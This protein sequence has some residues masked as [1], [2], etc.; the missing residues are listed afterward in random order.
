MNSSLD[1]FTSNHSPSH[2]LP[3]SHPAKA[4]NVSGMANRGRQWL[5][6]FF[7]PG[8]RETYRKKEGIEKLITSWLQ[9]TGAGNERIQGKLNYNQRKNG[10]RW[11]VIKLCL[12]AEPLSHWEMPGDLPLKLWPA[13]TWE[14]A[15]IQSL[16]P[17]PRLAA[18]WHA[19]QQ[20]CWV[21]CIYI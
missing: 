13:I 6:V 15:Q 21:I 5:C 14:L 10:A 11:L 1:S 4:S 9:N 17:H 16:R 7:S 8:W 18:W 20:L 2:I 19:L 12:W 3:P